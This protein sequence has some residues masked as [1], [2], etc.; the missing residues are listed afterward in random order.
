MGPHYEFSDQPLFTHSFHNLS[1]Y[2]KLL[3]QR[4]GSRVPHKSEV[5]VNT[6]DFPSTHPASIL[7][8]LSSPVIH[9]NC[10]TF[11][12]APTFDSQTAISRCAYR[13][14]INTI[15]NSNTQRRVSYLKRFSDVWS[16]AHS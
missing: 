16:Q 6:Q 15:N 14:N 12:S 5:K 13:N 10:I 11:L 9:E 2:D 1:E 7:H 4:D 3:F 8:K